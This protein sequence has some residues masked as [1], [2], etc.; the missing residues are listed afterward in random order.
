MVMP[1]QLKQ[2]CIFSGLAT[3]VRITLMNYV[4]FYSLLNFPEKDREDLQ[5]RTGQGHTELQLLFE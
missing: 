5:A 3:T 1:K 2:T 4:D